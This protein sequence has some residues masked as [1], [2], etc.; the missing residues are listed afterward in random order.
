M[1][2]VNLWLLSLAHWGIDLLTHMLPPVMPLLVR[3][4]DLSVARVAALATA[5]SVSS[6]LLQP[7]LGA[8]V[9]RSGRA[10]LLP[11][12]VIWCGVF[13]S[14]YGFASS[15][16]VLMAAAVLAGLGAALF[17]PLA[18]VGVR[19]VLG[20]FSAGGLSIF[21][22]GGTVGMASAPLFATMVVGWQ[23][24]AG[25]RWSIVPALLVAGAL[26]LG[27]LHR[28]PLIRPAAS[29]SAADGSHSPTSP[30][31]GAQ[32]TPAGGAHEAPAGDAPASPAGSAP[33]SPGAGQE[34]AAPA[35]PNAL[36]AL[37]YLAGGK[38]VRT[39]AQMAMANFL[40][41]Y[42][43]TL[44]APE[45]YAGLMLTVFLVVGSF[46]AVASG[47]LADQVGRKPVVILSSVLATPAF[48]GFLFTGGFVQ[49]AFLVL[50]SACM[51]ATFSVVPIYGQELV[52]TRPGMG[53][54]LLMGGV[55]ALASLCLI[56]LGSVADWA[57]VRL[58][59]LVAAL[60]P[61]LSAGLFLPV[62]ET[63][64]QS[65]PRLALTFPSRLVK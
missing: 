33:A 57:G 51:Y 5:L 41:L 28:L 12:T 3:E 58:A 44:G 6:G 17:H 30:A 23:G 47:Y 32:E 13:M 55:W 56:P 43:V 9:D 59:L 7:V 1:P 19:A 52:P 2:V 42:Y 4:L 46:S 22:V 39:I 31:G 34:A 11:A 61:L 45:S 8:A 62:P 25:L 21:S 10:W 24:L 38:F 26:V 35:S 20:R 29:G 49:A 65:K 63:R 54:G 64:P 60:L 40:P 50:T 53:A 18:S 48:I 16:W 36:R 14:V 27:G 37:A 15:Y